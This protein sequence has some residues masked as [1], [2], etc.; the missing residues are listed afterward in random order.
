VH[1]LSLA[2]ELS[3]ELVALGMALIELSL[4]A[5]NALFELRETA[6]FRVFALRFGRV[7]FWNRRRLR[8][9]SG[10]DLLAEP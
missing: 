3:S 6:G 4:Q 2:L 9:L 10:I 7:G 8:R 5:V 1:S